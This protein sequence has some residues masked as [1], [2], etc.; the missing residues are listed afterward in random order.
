MPFFEDF[1]VGQ[2]NSYGRY[3]VAR[4]EVIEFARR[5]DPQRFH[6]DEAAAAKTHFGRLAASGWHTTAM[7]MAMFVAA[8]DDADLPAIAAGPAGLDH[9]AVGDGDDRRAPAG[10]EVDAAMPPGEAKDR[11]DAHAE[12]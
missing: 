11:V 2:R 3:E 10:A 4:D 9:L 7:T 12:P 5:Y 8:M 6:L 1:Q